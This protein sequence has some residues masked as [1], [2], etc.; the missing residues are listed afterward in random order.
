MQ[1][2]GFRPSRRER[3]AAA[4]K[5]SR[6]IAKGAA[7]GAAL[8]LGVALA[9]GQ[10]AQA[11]VFN[12]TNL[13]DNGAGSLRQAIEDANGAA[14]ADTITFQTGLTGTI[15]LTTGQLEITDSVD[16]QGPGAAALTVSGN[17]SSR[18][19]Y[20]YNGSAALDV[21]ISGLTI[22]GGTAGVG[23]GIAD[24]GENL[25][26]DG[27]TV[28][29][30]AAS[31]DGG[32]LWADGQA[33][34][35]LTLTIRNS[36]ISGNTADLDGAGVYVGTPGGPV[37]IQ[38]TVI[39]GNDAL[40]DGGGI[41][42]YA[43][44][45]DTTIENSTIS[46]NTA[47]TGGGIFLYDTDGGLHTIR[48]TTISG[49]TAE[50]GGGLFV[51]QLDDPLIIE[52]STISGNQA[53]GGEGP[54][55]G[56]GVYLYSLYGGSLSIRHSTVAGNSATDAGGG[57]FTLAGPF[58]VEHT[59]V[60][61]NT[62]NA[63]P[64]LATADNGSFD[65]S[66]SLIETPGTAVFNDNGGNVLNQDPQLGPLQNNGGPTETHLPAATSPAVNAGDASFSPP[67]PTDQR[68]FAR[69]SGGRIDI[70][71]VERQVNAGTVQFLVSSASVNESAGTI[72]ITVTRTGG[73]EGAVSVSYL[74]I[75]GT[76]V[77]PG[78]YAAVAGT[79][80]WA[81]GDAAPKT[82][83]VTIVNDGVQEP[84]ESFSVTIFNPQGGAALGSP[85]TE[86]VTILDDD[87]VAIDP[88]EIPTLGD[89]GKI[90]LAALF[91]L[92]GVRLLR[93]KEPGRAEAE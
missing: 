36:E 24:F 50:V 46:G 63:D 64:D 66:F 62:A 80:N 12:V 72:T 51:Y 20:L 42:F 34:N 31:A 90:L 28:T 49:N 69:L 55:R 9:A 17:K 79:L 75:N 40:G 84:T 53:T 76:A 23:G 44:Y 48:G 70:G 41:F 21:T 82:F 77:T 16:V 6:E 68:G 43:P 45:T 60:G 86:V 38:N 59:I 87:T 32:G 81:D 73:S 35:T 92:G 25:V 88:A 27:V 85:T 71:A 78:D 11:A 93:R 13:N 47:F 5:R 22:T 10:P 33:G 4:R 3:R 15:T 7:S 58:M 14:G 89:F 61:D 26:L 18:V 52:N 67:P 19:F 39:S 57:L 65:V 74:T 37:L 8:T 30:N 91:G 83:Q 54:G 2:S 56:G 29:G 1:E